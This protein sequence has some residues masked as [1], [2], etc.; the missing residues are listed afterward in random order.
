MDGMRL[1]AD[2]PSP[3]GDG[4]SPVEW[5]RAIDVGCETTR[6]VTMDMIFFLL[7]LLLLLLAF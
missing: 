6:S 5:G 4:R 2:A 1:R 7:L 3:C